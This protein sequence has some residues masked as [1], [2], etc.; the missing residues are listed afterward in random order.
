[1]FYSCPQPYWIMQFEEVFTQVSK[2]GERVVFLRP[3]GQRSN[4]GRRPC[5]SVVYAALRLRV[6]LRTYPQLSVLANQQFRQVSAM[7][8]EE[9]FVPQCVRQ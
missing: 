8:S 7:Q 2:K 6:E 9:P 5:D 4:R 1:M 3:A